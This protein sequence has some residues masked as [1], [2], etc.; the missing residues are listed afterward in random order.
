MSMPLLCYKMTYL[1]L[2]DRQHSTENFLHPPEKAY[3]SKRQSYQQQGSRNKSRHTEG[4][5]STEKSFDSF[6]TTTT[7]GARSSESSRVEVTTTSFESS[8]T[9]SDSHSRRQRRLSFKGDS[10]Y[11]SAETQQFHYS[12]AR[13]SIA[14]ALDE[15]NVE[16][17]SQTNL[18][19]NHNLPQRTASRKRRDFQSRNLAVQRQTTDSITSCSS[20]EQDT[21]DSNPPPANSIAEANMSGS[22]L[23]IF[24]KLFRYSKYSRRRQN[25]R[26]FSIDEKSDM[27]FREFIRYDP[28]LDERSVTSQYIPEREN[29]LGRGE[30]V[31]CTS[32]AAIGVERSTT[33]A[34]S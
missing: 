7:D 30:T 14:F 12:P 4:N 24:N 2:E 19:A 25:Q 33:L 13:N 9:D 6:D 26:D 15:E 10:G 22:K 21:T 27:L 8:T 20:Y 5:S 29:E 3:S 32:A 23:N 17:T 34:C 18:P 11:K 16:S 28:S 1:F 31:A